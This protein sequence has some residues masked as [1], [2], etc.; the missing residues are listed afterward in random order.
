M[1]KYLNIDKE[2]N[3]VYDKEEKVYKKK[4]LLIKFNEYMEQAGFNVNWIETK[5]S[6]YE[7]A[8]TKRDREYKL[9]LYL[10]NITG[11]GWADKPHIKRVQ[12]SNVRKQDNSK[13]I[14]TN[15]KQT[16]LI[17]GYYNFDNNP[18]IVAWNAYHYVYH[19]TMRSCY[20]NIDNLKD[21]YT[22]GLVEAECAEHKIWVIKPERFEEFLISYIR[23]N[24]IGE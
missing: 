2:N 11:A 3:T 24:T 13:Y 9:V 15:G 21:G 14:D 12:V 17:I 20:V 22:N 6:P 8:I 7:V 23:E 5:S 10:K 18:I 4:D 1:A 19:E 16:I